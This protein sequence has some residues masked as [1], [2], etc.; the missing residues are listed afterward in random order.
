MSK[1]EAMRSFIEVASVGSFTKAAE[2]LDVSRIRVTRD[3][4]ELEDWL[5][6]RLLHRTTRR[7]SL[8]SAGEDAL[9]ICERM[10]NDAAELEN[11][12]HLHATELVGDI[13]I[14][15]PIGLGQTQLLP[16]IAAFSQLHPKVSF[17]LL[18]SDKNAQLVDERVD[19]AL[20]YTQQPQDNLIARRLFDVKSVICASPGYLERHGTPQ[21]L[22]EL[23][24]HRCLI[25]LDQHLWQ[26]PSGDEIA[27]A[28]PLRA[29]DA[30]T[31]V[32]A[33]IAGMGVA[34]LPMDLAE[35]RI[36][37]GDL[38]ALPAAFDLPTL[39][40]WAV[41]L[42]RSYQQPVVRAF[43]DYAVEKWATDKQ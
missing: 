42:S 39:S 23:K 37:S 5:Q 28:G 36:I 24:Q 9:H 29:N 32:K 6:V 20:R 12:A 15:A 14:A 26:F 22:Q 10:L 3:I 38:I 34:R 43:I 18:L 35:A 2:Q 1:L 33:A 30:V 8:T 11:R 19:I 21:T 17:Q 41:Y 40:V 4:Q 31:L 7:V 16:L 25:H 27:V 13:R